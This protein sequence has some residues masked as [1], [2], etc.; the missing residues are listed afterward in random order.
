MGEDYADHARRVPHEQ[1][2]A[3]VDALPVHKP[4]LNGSE[5]P[6]RRFELVPFDRIELQTS[7]NYVVK[8]LIPAEALTVIWGPPKCG[9]SFLVSDIAFHVALGWEW[10][11]KRVKAGPVVYVAAEGEHGFRARKEA[12]RQ[13]RLSNYSKPV[14]FYL[15]PASLDLAHEYGK[16]IRDIRESLGNKQP[17]MIVIDTLNRTM[18]GSESRDEDMAAYIKACDRIREEFSCAVVVVHHCGIETSRPRGHTSL[19]G[20]ADA[21]IAVKRARDGMMT[22]TIELMK[23]G[24]VGEVFASSLRVIEVGIDEDGDPITSCVVEPT[25]VPSNRKPNPRLSMKQDLALRALRDF[26]IEQ[27]T[28]SINEDSYRRILERDRVIDPKCSNPRARFNELRNALHGKGEIDVQDSLVILR[29]KEPSEY[30][31]GF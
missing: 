27:K 18:S 17:V 2:Q 15:V 20:A 23:D 25:D 26:C 11:G 30:N 8:G 1:R 10:R 21:Q 4:K 9:K 14:P 12:F 22:A 28:D 7:G 3:E 13:E 19:S 6:R 16:L 31:D 24:E 29:N 5:P